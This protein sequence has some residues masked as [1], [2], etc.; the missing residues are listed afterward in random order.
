MQPNKAN[1]KNHEMNEKNGMI[2]WLLALERNWLFVGYGLRQQ[3]G[4]KPK[5]K[6]SNATNQIQTYSI[7]FNSATVLI[8]F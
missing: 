2:C 4:N 3:P 7:L 5:K 1:Q 6:T 8:P